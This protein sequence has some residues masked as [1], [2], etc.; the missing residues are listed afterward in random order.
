MNKQELIT[1]LAARREAAGLG[2]AEIALRSGLTERSVRNALSLKGNP[3]LSSLLA[4]VDALGL[5]LQLAPK[6]F[7]ERADT[8]PGYRPVPTR[9]GN[10]VGAAAAPTAPASEPHARKRSP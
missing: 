8:E 9:I 7:G 10:A 3:Q 1:A 6:G 5:E 2:N 4:L